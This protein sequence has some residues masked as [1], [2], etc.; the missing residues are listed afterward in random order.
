MKQIPF[1]SKRNQVYP[2]LWR[3]HGAVKKYFAQMD[4][5]R[6]ESELY[7]ELGG[8]L[9]LPKVLYQRPGLLVLEYRPEP[10]LLAELERQEEYG[11]SP[12]PWRSLA[13]WLRQCHTLSGRLPEEGNLR[14]F[15]WSPSDGQAIGLDLER[16]RPDTL[17]LCGARL[18]AAMLTYAPENTAVKRQAA[19]VLASELSVPDS[20]AE[21]TVLAL[22]AR[23]RGR[24]AK[25]VSGV[26]LAGG[27]SRRM[28]KNKAELQLMG[29]SLLQHQVDKLHALGLQDIMLSGAECPSLPGVRVIPDE[30]IGKGPLGGL[31]ACLRAAQN[32]ACLVVSVDVPLI[33]TAALSHLCRTHNGG[34]TVLR[35]DGQEEPLL[36]V[37]DRCTADYISMLIESGRYAVHGLKDTVSWS[38]F[39]YFGPEE[40]LMNCNTP[41]EF[42]AA[43]RLAVFFHS[44]LCPVYSQRQAGPLC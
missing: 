6:L 38:Y 16:Y 9:P 39:D 17:E 11:F 34:I 8:S 21:G 32:S 44:T 10:T 13:T 36:G 28:G 33:P 42:A 2:A 29:K 15:L 14:N 43:E 12:L 5:W 40:F 27:A 26:I 7:A 37:Y 22:C 19:Q 4:D 41:E 1:Y 25:S 23:R 31:H 30:Y 24:Q 35:H 20:L 18:M 3:G